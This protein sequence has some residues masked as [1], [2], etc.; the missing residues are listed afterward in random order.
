MNNYERYF[1]TPE[2]TAA[3]LKDMEEG[4]ADAHERCDPDIL[5]MDIADPIDWIIEQAGLGTPKKHTTHSIIEWLKEES[6]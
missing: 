5:A 3:S 6:E 4:M 1:G 2:R